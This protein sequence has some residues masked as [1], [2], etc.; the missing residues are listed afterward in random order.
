MS[1]CVEVH[2][3]AGGREEADRICAAVVERRVAACAQVVAPITSTYRWQGRVERSEEWL[4]FMKTTAQRF[5]DLAAVVR[6]LHSYDVPE[7]V[8]IPLAGGTPD[9]LDWIRTET[10]PAA[11]ERS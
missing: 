10:S 6:E 4:L 2:V 1:D 9:Y 11:P 7:I 3:T 8:A 5:D